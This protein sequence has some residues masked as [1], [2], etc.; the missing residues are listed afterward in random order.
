MATLEKIREHIATSKSKVAEEI[1]KAEAPENSLD[2]RRQKKKLKRLTRK[3][4]KMVYFE[5][6]AEEKKKSKKAVKAEAS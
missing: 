3:A 6:K 2:V 4:S 5:K 1:K